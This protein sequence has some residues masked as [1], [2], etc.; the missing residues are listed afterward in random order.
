MKKIFLFI[1]YKLTEKPI[2]ATTHIIEISC[3][4]FNKEYIDNKIISCLCFFAKSKQK[5][6]GVK[7]GH[8]IKLLSFIEMNTRT[9]KRFESIDSIKEVTEYCKNWSK[10]YIDKHGDIFN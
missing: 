10:N 7:R 9:E 1:K 5:L 6:K 3:Y 2:D 4:K 8:I